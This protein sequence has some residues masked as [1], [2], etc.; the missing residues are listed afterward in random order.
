MKILTVSFLAAASLCAA[1][2]PPTF[3]E[4][5]SIQRSFDD[6][7]AA[8]SAYS[9]AARASHPAIWIGDTREE[10][11]RFVQAW[12]DC[13]GA[14]PGALTGEIVVTREPGPLTI[15]R[16]EVRTGATRSQDE[17]SAERRRARTKKT[18]EEIVAL[19]KRMP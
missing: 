10:A 8:V 3:T 15:T 19:L 13:A 18:L 11:S 17:T 5:R 12:M 7:K 16:L 1:G 14:P 9:S 2:E 4:S 6:V